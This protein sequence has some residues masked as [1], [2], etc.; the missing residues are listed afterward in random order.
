VSYIPSPWPGI[1]SQ[2]PQPLPHNPVLGF[3]THNHRC[4]TGFK[5]KVTQSHPSFFIYYLGFFS[6]RQRHPPLPYC[7]A[8]LWY[9]IQKTKQ[10]K[11]KNQT[12]TKTKQNKKNQKNKTTTTTKT[13][14]VFHP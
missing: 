5:I 12:K 7:L 2:T 14:S 11:T 9:E 13:G 4:I 1:W 10:N 6:R 3:Y 8:A